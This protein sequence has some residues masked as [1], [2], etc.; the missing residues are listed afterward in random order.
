TTAMAFEYFVFMNVD[1]AVIET[2]L[3]GRL[4]AT[5]VLDP[6]ACVI[7]SISLEH[8]NVLG[9]KL[10]QIAYEKSEIIK[11]GSKVFVGLIPE[12]AIKV[13]EQKTESVKSE[14]YCLEEYIVAKNDNLQ[15]YTEEIEFDEW[16]VPLI[17]KHQKYNAAL[18]AL[19]IAKTFN[20]DDPSIITNGI[21]NVIKNTKLQGRYEIV[22]NKPRIILD[23]AHNP[24]GI[25]SIANEFRS[26]KYKYPRSVI[27]FSVMKDKNI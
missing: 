12:E 1:Y 11:K 21:K 7:T 4:D 23:S 5:N 17:G 22:L 16:E 6:L 10:E 3:G 14:L 20:I 27:L 18:A 25:Q 9:E 26:E 15:L 19:C 13:V 8:T 24:E 2:G